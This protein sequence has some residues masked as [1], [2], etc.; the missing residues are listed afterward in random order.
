MRRVESAGTRAQRAPIPPTQFARPVW[1]CTSA[2]ACAAQQRG[3][4]PRG[5]EREVVAHRD[6]LDREA[7]AARLALGAAAGRAHE[8]VRVPAR[9][10]ALHQQEHLHFSAREPAL[11]G[12][13]RDAQ[14]SAAHA[15]RISARSASGA[16]V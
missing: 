7:A 16:S 15:E 14:R 1:Q 2:G 5:A 11:A 9:A 4:P 13:V 8:Q 6:A 12:D 3:D 10:Q